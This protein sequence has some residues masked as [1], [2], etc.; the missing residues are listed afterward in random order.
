MVHARL[1]E[2]LYARMEDDPE[3]PMTTFNGA[4]WLNGVKILKCMDDPTRNSDDLTVVMLESGKKRLLVA[5]CYI[6]H[7]RTAPLISLVE[8]SPKDQQLLLGA[9]ANAHH[10]VW[11][12][13]DIND[14]VGEKNKYM[15]EAEA[16]REDDK[17]AL[18]QLKT[19]TM[20][21]QVLQ[22][23]KNL[24][25]IM[26][27]LSL[28]CQNAQKAQSTSIISP[29]SFSKV[30]PEFDGQNIPVEQWFVN[31]EKNA[32]AYVLDEKQRY[33]QARSKMTKAAALF[34]NTVFVGTYNE[35][36]SVLI[37]EFK[38]TYASADVHKKLGE[39]KKQEAESFHEYVLQ[40]RQIAALV[41]G[42]DVMSVIRYIV[43]GLN[44]KNEYK[45]SMYSCKSYDE[46]Q[47]QYA[48]FEQMT[49][50]EPVHKHTAGAGKKPD[51]AGR[52]VHC[53]NCADVSIVKASVFKMFPDAQLEKSVALLRGLGNTKTFQKGYFFAEV[54]VDNI[55]VQQKFVVVPDDKLEYNGLLGYDLMSKFCV[56]LDKDGFHFSQKFEPV[57]RSMVKSYKPESPAAKSPIELKIVPSSPMTP[58][59][60]QP[61]RYSMVECAAIRDQVAEWLQSGVVRKSTSNFGSRVVIVK[62]KDGSNRVC[63]DFRQLNAMVLKDCFPVP[64][65]DDVL[66]KLQ[67]AKLKTTNKPAE[68][69]AEFKMDTEEL[70]AFNQLKA[71]LCQEPVLR[72]YSQNAHTE[73]H[74]DASKDGFGATLLQR[75]GE[76]LHPIFFWSKKT[77]ES[78]S[79]RHSYILEVK[80]AYLA[81][82]KFRHYLLG[83]NFVLKAPFELMFG[84]KMLTNITYKLTS[85][86]EQELMEDFEMERQEMRREA[87]RM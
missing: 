9:E 32:D 72:I 11:G 15:A 64:L 1:V 29:E 77:S 66:E 34:L 35:L 67:A 78:D 82:E 16:Q 68:K 10:C 3:A 43:D 49:Q 22:N 27:F 37:A 76:N 57:T 41:D 75:F 52:A 87:N 54:L 30:V 47:S 59:K 36:K 25:E 48:I 31:F 70:N 74:T 2:S 33:V 12:S 46:L 7:D 20:E 5:S 26:K 18:N 62:K 45:Y 65:M 8:A 86:L 50:R 84:T 28:Q 79:K 71:S 83:V 80:A 42:V 4:A 61:S 6:A 63:V 23:S 21:Q 51:Y 53:F 73:L 81:I 39:R 24:E 14:R 17:L 55:K 85:I 19:P 40:M 56:V 69:D 60:Q 44:I 58:F 38:R 13:P